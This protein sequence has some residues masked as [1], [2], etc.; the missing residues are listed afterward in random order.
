MAHNRFPQLFGPKNGDYL[1]ALV[2]KIGDD[3]SHRVYFYTSAGPGLPDWDQVKKDLYD[4][5]EGRTAAFTPVDARLYTGQ[6][7]IAYYDD[8]GFHKN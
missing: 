4:V 5:Y 6:Q 7:L 3:F 8:T 1:I 2:A